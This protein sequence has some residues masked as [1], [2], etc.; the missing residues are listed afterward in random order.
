MSSNPS[1]PPGTDTLP[2]PKDDLRLQDVPPRNG[3]GD[4][5][6]L[7]RMPD[8]PEPASDHGRVAGHVLHPIAQG[9]RAPL[10]RKE[11][12]APPTSDNDITDLF[13]ND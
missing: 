13:S 1:G 4:V 11:A 5:H 7:H 8:L 3:A 12:A 2:N 10:A 6:P 9:F